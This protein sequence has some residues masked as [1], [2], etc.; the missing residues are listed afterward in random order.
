MSFESRIT[1]LDL[2]RRDEGQL[3]F[4][5]SLLLDERGTDEGEGHGFDQLDKSAELS[6]WF[7]ARATPDEVLAWYRRQLT[8]S[9]WALTGPVRGASGDIYRRQR[10]TLWVIIRPQDPRDVGPSPY[11]R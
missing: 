7:R 3:V 11:L 1:S 9:G 8:A 10:E 4:P 2:A 6:R 5:G